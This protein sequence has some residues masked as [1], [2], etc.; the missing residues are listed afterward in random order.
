MLL[1]LSNLPNIASLSSPILVSFK[2]YSLLALL[3]HVCR[4]V[5]NMPSGIGTMRHYLT[6]VYW[7]QYYNI[8]V[9]ESSIKMSASMILQVMHAS[10]KLLFTLS[11]EQ[12][13]EEKKG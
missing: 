1:V 2:Y 10:G 4:P 11:Q 8:G 7:H 12:K 5:S 13:N 9:K 6:K 3:L